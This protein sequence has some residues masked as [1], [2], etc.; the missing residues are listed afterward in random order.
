MASR[1][2]SQIARALLR[3]GFRYANSDHRRLVLYVEDSETDIRTKVSHGNQDYGDDL[4]TKVRKQLHLTT[5][6]DL[7]RLV[8]CPMSGEDYLEA[9]RGQ[10]DL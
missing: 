8:D 9:L 5:K 6:A 1:K 3:K 7:L 4:L 2:G 10:G